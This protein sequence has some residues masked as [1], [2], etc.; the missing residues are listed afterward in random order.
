MKAWLFTGAR[1]PLQLI[2]RET[3]R[4]GPDEVLLEVRAAGL[5]H[6]DVGRMDGTLTPYL[7]KKPPIILGHE[8]AAVVAA[9]G[10]GVSDYQLGDRVVAS[11]T[12]EYCPGWSADGGYASHCVVPARVLVP[13]PDA[14]SFVQGA[15]ATDAGQT[16]HRAVMV[17]GGLRAGQRVGVVGL[18]GLGMT[19]AR[20]AVLRGAQVFGAEPRREAWAAARAQGV[21]E[22]V[23]D[24]LQLASYDLDLIVDFAGFGVT[25]AG[26][27]RAV[28]PGGL[29]VQVGLGRTEATISTAELVARSVTLRGSGGG[30]PSDTSAV[31]ALMATGELIIPA[32][33]IGFEDIPA[34]LERLERGGVVGRI[35]AEVS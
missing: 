11:G 5:C 24:V 29:V 20:I 4:P 8:I 32:S 17:A 12:T 34:G 19:G 30:R 33:T 22:V 9:V 23:E 35:V 16:S 2:E 31:L 28:R 3:P 27:I 13:L 14:V 15:A 7:P 25:T 6:S 21:T 10:A 18:G 26:A 1:Q